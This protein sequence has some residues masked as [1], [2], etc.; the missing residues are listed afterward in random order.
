MNVEIKKGNDATSDEQFQKFVEEA[1]RECFTPLD[2]ALDVADYL[3]NQIEK[4]VEELEPLDG[5]PQKRQLQKQLGRAILK[6]LEA[7]HR[8]APPASS[9]S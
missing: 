8:I 7:F 9:R 1:V 3:L 4:R 6:I 2:R 5:S